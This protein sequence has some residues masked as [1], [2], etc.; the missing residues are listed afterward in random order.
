ML[1][2]RKTSVTTFVLFIVGMLV[3]SRKSRTTDDTTD[4][5]HNVLSHAAC[6]SQA[7]NL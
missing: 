6:R 3:T 1:H 4:K 5:S 2:V 7:E